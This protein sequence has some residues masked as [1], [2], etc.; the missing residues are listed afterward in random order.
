MS[1][2]CAPLVALHPVQSRRSPVRK[3]RGYEQLRL[4]PIP[5]SYESLLSLVNARRSSPGQSHLELGSGT[6]VVLKANGAAAPFELNDS[7]LR[8]RGMVFTSIEM[9]PFGG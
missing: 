1:Q 5:S 4:N 6:E 3:L 7:G 9:R 8:P 2:R